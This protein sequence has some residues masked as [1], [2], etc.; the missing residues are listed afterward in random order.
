MRIGER[1]AAVA[2]QVMGGGKWQ[3]R[4]HSPQQTARNPQFA[5][6][7][8]RANASKS[9]THWHGPDRGV[10]FLPLALPNVYVAYSTEESELTEVFHNDIRGRFNRGEP[11][12]VQAMGR[13]AALAAQARE[14]LLQGD[15]ERLNRCIDDNFEQ[16]RAIYQLP[17]GQ[18]AMVEAARSVG[19]S[20]NFAG[21]GGAIVGLYRD[22]AMSAELEKVLGAIG[23]QI[24]KPLF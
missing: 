23:C 8:E 24:V 12:V 7:N 10:F 14:A 9:G 17:N 22:E 21:S 11:A 4:W 6:Q 3:A 19:A 18:V 13:C 2:G 20:A 15:R 1:C 16:R 5:V